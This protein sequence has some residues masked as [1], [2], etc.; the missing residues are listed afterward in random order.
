MSRIYD[1]TVGRAFTGWYGQ[2]MSRIDARG[3]GEVRR[4]L[5][6]QASGRVLD[7]GTGT[8]A[9]LDFF[10]AELDE[11][12]LSEPSPNM[13]RALRRKLDHRGR[14]DIEVVRAPAEALP[15][16]ASSFDYVTCTMVMCTMPD[17]EA[18][19]QEVARVLKP[20]GSLLFL[21]HVRSEE[22]RI[23][24]VQDRL[25]RPWRFLAAG[26]HC[27]RDSLAAVEA[28]PLTLLSMRRD[29][30]PLAPRFMKP[31]VIGSATR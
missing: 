5:L 31:L 16:D 2:M 23:A 12:V 4:Q 3:L 25:E 28:S 11:L 19:L 20:G 7:L 15:F 17:P 27:N 1:E 26:C 22:P 21:E 6:S 14:F 29:L 24:R 8:D 13:A 9:N 10:P 30:M 18:G